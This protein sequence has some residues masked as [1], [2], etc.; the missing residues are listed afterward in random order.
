M[1]QAVIV[2]ASASDDAPEVGETFR[3]VARS[4]SLTYRADDRRPHSRGWLVT[5]KRVD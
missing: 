3:T 2:A 5:L 4:R 1:G